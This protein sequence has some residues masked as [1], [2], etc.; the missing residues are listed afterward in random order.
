MDKKTPSTEKELTGITCV[1]FD[2]DGTLI[3]TVDLIHRSFDYA[4]K[5]VLGESLTKSQLLQNMGRPLEVQMNSFSSA[6]TE[7]LM[8]AY[9]QHNL[10]EHDKYIKAYPYAEEILSWL[11]DEKGLRIGIV[12]SKRRSLSLRGLKIAGLLGGLIDEVVAM[13]D[14]T[15]HKPDP[16]PV[17]IALDLLACQASDTLFVGDSPFD[18]ESGISAGVYTGAA[19]WGPFEPGSLRQLKPDIELDNLKELKTYLA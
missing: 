16:E 12:T 3:D 4:V 8:T 7:E 2:L 14:S 1:L 9:N 19:L 11:K 13:E 17:K 18:I 5:K 10:A 6:K 15:R